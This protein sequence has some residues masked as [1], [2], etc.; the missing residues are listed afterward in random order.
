MK[1]LRY[2]EKTEAKFKDEALRE[3]VRNEA[4]ACLP[5]Q[6]EYY[7]G[8]CDKKVPFHAK[9]LY[10]MMGNGI[11]CYVHE[12]KYPEQ[13]PHREIVDKKIYDKLG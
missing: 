8:T 6:I 5:A 7:C 11:E 9:T 1:T 2:Y 4:Y 12:I 3:R 13:N 10:D